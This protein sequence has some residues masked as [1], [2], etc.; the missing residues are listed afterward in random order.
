MHCPAFQGVE[1]SMS[2]IRVLAQY[3]H[4]S[5]PTQHTSNIVHEC[6]YC[7]KESLC[8]INSIVIKLYATLI[9]LYMKK[10]AFIEYCYVVCL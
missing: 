9:L 8:E 3:M 7:S 4:I 5:L 10:F 1:S 6:E 2:I